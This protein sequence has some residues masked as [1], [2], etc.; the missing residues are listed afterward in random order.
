MLLFLWNNRCDL[1]LSSLFF[2]LLVPPT[3][4]GVVCGLWNVHL[5]LW[6]PLS[7]PPEQIIWLVQPVA[8]VPSVKTGGWGHTV[9]EAGSTVLMGQRVTGNS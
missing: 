6:G 2:H 1:Q 4:Q 9:L 5:A 3:R 8:L 7:K